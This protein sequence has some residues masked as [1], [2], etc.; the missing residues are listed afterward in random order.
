MTA[1]VEV[2]EI[3]VIA[4]EVG[5]RARKPRVY[6]WPEDFNPLEDM[7]SGRRWA[8]PERAYAPMVAAIV[9]VIRD[10]PAGTTRLR[11]SQT[12][13]CSCKCSPGFIVEDVPAGAHTTV[14]DVHIH[15]RLAAERATDASQA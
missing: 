4:D 6:V 10:V 3:K 5:A 9:D 15:Y 14:N 12:A 11:W 1:T 7:A 2:T 13:G 8:R